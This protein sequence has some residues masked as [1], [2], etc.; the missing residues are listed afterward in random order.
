MGFQ[1]DE[2]TTK[3]VV[4]SLTFA[5]V[6]RRVYNIGGANPA[7]IVP[8]RGTLIVLRDVTV[9]SHTFDLLGTYVLDFGYAPQRSGG[10]QSTWIEYAQP[11][12]FGGSAGTTHYQELLGS[13]TIPS[14]G[15]RRRDVIRIGVSDTK[16]N[17]PS[18]GDLM[19]GDSG[20]T[21][22]RCVDAPWLSPEQSPITGL[23][24]QRA[25]YRSFKTYR[26]T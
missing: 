10:R 7:T 23:W 1:E 9:T 13:R 8:A 21:G 22:R 19:P 16:A 20:L 17:G 4:R 6:H 26:G 3:R 24:F 11:L 14:D 15:R 12:P 5:T 18:E 2:D 25:T